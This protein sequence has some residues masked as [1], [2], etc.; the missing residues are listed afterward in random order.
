MDLPGNFDHPSFLA[1]FGTGF[2]YLVILGVMTALL[3]GL[4]YLFFDIYV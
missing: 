2:G 3:F 1:A 4:P